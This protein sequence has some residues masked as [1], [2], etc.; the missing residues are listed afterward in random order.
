M[1]KI[2]ILIVDDHKLIREAWVEFLS[3]D[4]R[5][6]VVGDAENP[7]DAVR[8]VTE[9]KPRIVLMDLNMSPVDGFEGTKMIRS[10]SPGSKVIGISMSNMPEHAR[11]I[12][13]MGAKG[14][15][16]KNSTS[17]ELKIAILTV[18]KG[19]EYI[20]AEVKDL[21]GERKDKTNQKLNLNSLSKRELEIV[22]L[23]RDGLSSKDIAKRL[24]IS[25]KTVEV[26]RY[27]LMKKLEIKNVASLVDLVNRSGFI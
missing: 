16:T 12:F 6:E 1:D 4:P 13:Q 2:T 9:K 20:C 21:I 8:I 23:I 17:D 3:S 14:Y 25:V 22:K 10:A 27:N 11:R 19:G 24:V 15:I 26:H 5:M 18:D 7:T